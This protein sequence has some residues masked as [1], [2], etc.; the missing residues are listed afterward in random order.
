MVGAAGAAAQQVQVAAA[1]MAAKA[2]MGGMEAQ[3]MY[4][5]HST[6]RE[7]T[8]FLQVGFPAVEVIP[9]LLVRPETLAPAATR[10]PAHR[11]AGIRAQMGPFLEQVPWQ[12]AWDPAIQGHLGHHPEQM[13]APQLQTGQIPMEG[14]AGTILIA[15]SGRAI[16]LALV[17]RSS[18][19]LK[20][21]AFIL[22]LR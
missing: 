12:Q 17:A 14:L 11:R 3:S 4:R 10:E 8:H 16:T 2:E 18:S 5:F 6:A 7:Q 19:T 20:L 22:L 21:R 13:E 15:I 1:A 9:V